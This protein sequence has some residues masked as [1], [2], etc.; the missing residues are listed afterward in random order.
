MRIKLEWQILTISLI[1]RLYGTYQRHV[2]NTHPII[3]CGI[4]NCRTCH[5]FFELY[6]YNTY[7]LSLLLLNPKK[8]GSMICWQKRKNSKLRNLQK[9]ISEIRQQCFSSFLMNRWRVETMVTAKNIFTYSNRNSTRVNFSGGGVEP[10]D[11]NLF[12]C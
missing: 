7:R 5:K 8:S 11:R 6:P 12:N 9:T 2:S 3:K 10:N 1:Q 4:H